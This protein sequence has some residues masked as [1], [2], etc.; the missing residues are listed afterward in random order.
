[1]QWPDPLRPPDLAP[2]ASSSCCCCYWQR[3]PRTPREEADLAT[4]QRHR[5]PEVVDDAR[6]VVVGLGAR[7]QRRHDVHLKQNY[8]HARIQQIEIKISLTCLL[9]M[10]MGVRRTCQRTD[11]SSG[12]VVREPG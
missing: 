11:S 7:A 5:R 2:P 4:E 6:V 10:E 1:M 3:W 12:G 9:E 8:F